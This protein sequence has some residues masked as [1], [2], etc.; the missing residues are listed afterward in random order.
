MKNKTLKTLLISIFLITGCVT[1]AD[2]NFSNINQAIAVNDFDTVYSE[3]ENPNGLMYTARDSVLEKLDK[4]VI[5]HYAGQYER[6]NQELSDAEMLM[7]K[8]KAVSVTQT[9]GAFMENDTVMDYSGDPYED[10]YT[11]IFMALNYMQLGKKDDAFVEIRRMD[12]KL[13]ALSVEYRKQI[14]K[15]KQELQKNSKSVPEDSVKFHNSALAR[16]LSMLM[17]RSEGDYSNAEI[18]Y[19]YIKQAFQLQSDIYNFNVPECIK[20]DYKKTADARLNVIS[21]SGRAPVKREEQIPLFAEDTFYRVSLPVMEPR[22]TSISGAR[23]TAINAETGETFTAAAEKLESIQNI[24]LDTYSEK[25]ALI[26]ARTIGRMVTK[27]AGT[28]TLDSVSNNVD[29][30]GLSIIFGIAGLASRIH[31]F[32]SERAD[33][34]TSRYFPNNVFVSGIDLP[35]GTYNITVEYLNKK[36]VVATEYFKKNVSKSDLNLVESFCLK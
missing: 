26:V 21:F 18:D 3:L 31:M 4:G 23:I 10:I 32:A 5:S 22:E 28:A 34:R 7:E 9:I 24:A 17:Y 14:A 6:S 12:N 36:H 1:V 20:N 8:F 29:D 25:Y 16:Y 11:N 27:I 13:K 2:Y 33:V 35:A 15:R 30:A 19:K